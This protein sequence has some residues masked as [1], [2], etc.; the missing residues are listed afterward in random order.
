MTVDPALLPWLEFNCL[1]VESEKW[2]PL[3]DCRPNAS[4]TVGVF[5]SQ[6]AINKAFGSIKVKRNDAWPIGTFT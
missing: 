6:A 4:V 2:Q 3:P 5:R 1:G